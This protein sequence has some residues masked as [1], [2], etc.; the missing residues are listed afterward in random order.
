MSVG[1]EPLLLFLDTAGTRWE[2]VV[3]RMYNVRDS[4]HSELATVMDD[5]RT[6][7]A[8]FRRDAGVMKDNFALD[9]PFNPMTFSP[10]GCARPVGPARSLFTVL[11]LPL[12]WLQM[13]HTTAFLYSTIESHS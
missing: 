6:D 1:T 9:G 5:A 7:I 10:S 11:M 12:F 2:T 13:T 8:T 4:I 3:N